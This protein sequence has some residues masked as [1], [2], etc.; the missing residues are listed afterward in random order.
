MGRS[1][2][3]R[4]VGETDGRNWPPRFGQSTPAVATIVAPP[5]SGV[6]E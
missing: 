3:Q 4:L 2:I 5:P 1:I 6:N